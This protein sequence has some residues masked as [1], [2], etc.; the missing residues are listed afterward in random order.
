MPAST[1]QKV[2][3]L[4]KKIGYTAT[5]SGLAEDSSLSGT[6]KAPF[7]EAI[8]SPI[9]IPS[10]NI[11]ADSTHIPAT[12][13]GSDTAY[14]KGYRTAT[15]LRMTAD[16]SVSGSRAFIAYTT[17]NN[18]STP[19]LG[20][21]IDTQ[22]G[23][24][25]IVKVYK[26]DPNSSGVQL[27]AAGA[28]SNDTWFF[29]YASGVLNFNGTQIPSG[30][31]DTNIYIVAYRYIGAK[32]AR[33]AAGI[34]TFKDLYVTG[35]STFV[36]VGTFNSH[37]YV[38]GN[39]EVKGTTKFDGGTITLGDAANDNV[40]FG[41]DVDSHIIPDDNITYCLL[42]TSPSPRDKRQSRMPSSA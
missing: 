34:A 21:W 18:N 11:W 10:S 12:P 31:T 40:V 42:Y 6:K 16:S 33:P 22:F 41:A 29:D 32:G 26:G 2:D 19:I 3:F 9:A 27:S 20:D 14:V 37:L 15:A 7:A 17:Y 13:P 30:V 28:G 25:Y 38:G 1:E 24:D 8:P 39:L 23:A 4:L 35:L 36:G 5:K